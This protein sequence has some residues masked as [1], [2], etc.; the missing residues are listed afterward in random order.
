MNQDL[1]LYGYKYSVYA[2]IVAAVL[3]LKELEYRWVEVSPFA[4]PDPILT[5][6]HPFHRVPVVSHGTFT[7][8]ETATITRYLDASFPQNPLQPEDPKALARMTQIICMVDSYAYWPLVRQ[9]FSQRIFRP[10]IGERTDPAQLA[11]GLAQSRKVLAALEAIAKEGR[12]LD[13]ARITLADC[14]LAP[15]IAYF[16]EA[17]EGQEMLSGF[18]NLLTWWKKVESCDWMATTKP[19]LDRLAPDN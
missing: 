11:E 1:T 19:D 3:T 15:M 8:F 17:P 7:L 4:A 2:R 5:R 13:P 18:P 12:V 9:V 16:V 6:L 14:H 10:R